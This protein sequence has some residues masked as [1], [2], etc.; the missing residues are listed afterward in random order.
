[1]NIR[2]LLLLLLILV[3]AGFAAINWNAFSA[4]TTLSLAVTTIEAPLGLIMLGA[5]VLLAMIALVFAA[6]LKT[7]MLVASHNHSREM[8]ALR[9][10]A[11]QSEASRLT[12]LQRVLESES[13]KQQDS[14]T[15]VKVLMLSR[16]EEVE[17]S[18]RTA[19]EQNGN[20]LAAYIGEL[21][22]RLQ[23]QN[24]TSAAD[25]VR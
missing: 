9:K 20:S 22:D 10:L 11:D 13:Q 21:E 8:Q 23:R 18:L 25:L 15:E 24:G 16:L 17:C 19:L 12:E 1:M 4:P 5:T 3:I 6:Y 7:T 2:T 14:R